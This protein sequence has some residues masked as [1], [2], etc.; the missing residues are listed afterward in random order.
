MCAQSLEEI[1]V[2]ASKRGAQSVQDVPM[3]ISVLT[4][5]TLERT[6][7]EGFED[8]IKLVPGLTS[9][10]SGTGQSQVVIRGINSARVIHTSTQSRPLAGIYI[11]EMPISL[12]GFNPDLGVEDVNRIEVLRGPQGTLYGASSMS[13]TVRI[14]TNNP[15]TEATSGRVYAD[16]SDT[17]N[18]GTNYGLRGH[19]NIPMSDEWALRLVGWGQ[20]RAGFID[21][22]APG[23]EEEDYNDEDIAGGRAK[24]GYFGE[25]LTAIATLMYNKLEADGRSDEYVL[26]PT[27]PRVSAIT[28]ELQTVKAVPDTFTNEFTSFNFNFDYDFGSVMLTSAT[29]FL[30]TDVSN[31]LDDTFRVVA[32]TPIRNPNGPNISDFRNETEYKSTIQEFRLTSQY[33]SPLQW[34]VGAYYEDFSRDFAQTQPTPGTNAFFEFLTSIGA[35]P[36]NVCGT[37]VTTCFGAVENS[38][39]DGL[40]TVDS[41]Q[42]ALFGEVTYSFTD[43]FRMTLGARWYDYEND[44]SIFAAGPANSGISLDEPTIEESDWVPKVEFSYDVDESKMIYATYSEG[45][46][47]GQAQGFVPAATGISCTDQLD[48]LGTFSGAT[49]DGDKIKNYEIGAKTMWAGNSLTANV[50]LFRN[51]FNDM[52][53]IINLDCGFFQGLNAGKV[54][55]TGIEADI[56]HQASD[57]WTWNLGFSYVDSEVKEAFPG[58]NEPGDIPPYIPEWT[59]SAGVEYNTDIGNGS[60][61]VRA[62]VRYVDSMFNEFSS[63]ATAEELPSFTI[64]DLTLGYVI[65]DWTFNIFA[66]NLF[67]ETVVTNIDPD[68]VQPS[69]LTRSRPRTI[70]VGVTRHF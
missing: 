9:I 13:G 3:S 32:V 55:N 69:Q 65:D 7:V 48:E 51:E 66:K 30:K 17:K 27:D 52:Q 61:W 31:R 67:D 20:H 60:G 21:N 57:E 2:T 35:F 44:I 25:N 29:T 28:D 4:S 10:S 63:R 19:V 37:L 18:G 58:L 62:N 6:I 15:D 39:F 50:A 34:I 70:G 59:V 16:V 54:E 42:I 33:E 49:V 12:T 40:E 8:Y 23:F 22:V 53:T 38:A 46:R 14:I 64:F 24:L 45:F 26:D 68:R 47:L 43:A 5:E 41:K 1:V 36:P 56:F 11:D